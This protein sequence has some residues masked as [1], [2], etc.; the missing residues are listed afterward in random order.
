MTDWFRSWHGAPTDPKWLFVAKKAQVAPGVVAAVYWALLDHASQQPGR[1][2]VSNFDVETYSLFS[3]FAETDVSNIIAALNDK[4]LIRKGKLTA[5]EKRQPKREDSS[6][7]RTK[8][9]RE[10]TVTQRDARGEENRTEESRKIRLVASATDD[11]FEKVWKLYPK[12]KGGNPKDPTR[13][14]F[15]EARKSGVSLDQIT[16]ALRAGT[17]FDTD[18]IGTEFI[19]QAVKWFRD[20]RYLDHAPNEKFGFN[21][22]ASTPKQ[23]EAWRAKLIADGKDTRFMDAQRE[24]GGNWT[25]ETEWP[26]G[27]AP[28]QEAAE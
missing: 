5:W 27:Y 6:T 24:R 20:K 1:G 17:G 11:E 23:W 14:L 18:K 10:R 21:L 19:P 3:G 15:L 25:V 16:G 2:V 26:P 8:K 7:E 9:Y 13:K 28:A 12:R 4:G 22:N